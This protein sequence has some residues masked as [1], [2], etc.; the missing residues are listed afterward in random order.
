MAKIVANAYEQ[1]KLGTRA[2]V[3]RALGGDQ[4]VRGGSRFFT[5][6]GRLRP[7]SSLKSDR[8][9]GQFNHW[10]SH[11]PRVLAATEKLQNAATQQAIADAH[12]K[13]G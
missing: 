6:D 11:D 13:C 2:Q 10:M 7:Y 9:I 5:E 12:A 4:G 8:E 1:G 3:E